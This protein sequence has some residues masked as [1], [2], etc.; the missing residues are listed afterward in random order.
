[1]KKRNPIARDL[2]TSKY[3]VRIVPARKGRGPYKRQKE[4]VDVD[5]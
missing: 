5:R 2:A 3:H 1:M 4:S